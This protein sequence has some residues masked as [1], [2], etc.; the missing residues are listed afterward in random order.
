MI[1]EAGAEHVAAG[2][3]LEHT[4]G[5]RE[6]VSVHLRTVMDKTVSAAKTL[7]QVQ[8]QV[9][10]QTPEK[11]SQCAGESQEASGVSD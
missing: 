1:Q 11:A 3:Y 2:C 4:P 5:G 8:V 6:R 10:T 9:Q 7:V